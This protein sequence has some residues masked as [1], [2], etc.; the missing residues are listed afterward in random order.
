[1]LFFQ[2]PWKFHALRP[3]VFFFFFQKYPNKLSLS[4]GN[5][6][7]GHS[8]DITLTIKNNMLQT[9]NGS[10]LYLKGSHLC[11]TTELM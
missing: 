3:P 7:V 6:L 1:M 11:F 4:C 5:Q 10:Y 8:G 9:F 2:Y